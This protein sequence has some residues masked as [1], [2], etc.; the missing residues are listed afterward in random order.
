MA[1]KRYR[2]LIKLCNECAVTCGHC[3]VSCLN[4]KDVEMMRQCIR[5]DLDCATFC[6]VAAEL[7]S[8]DSDHADKFLAL[9]AEVCQ[10]CADECSKHKHQHCKDCADICSRCAEACMELAA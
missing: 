3:A 8:R 7:M 10:A 6:R 9:C 5:L 2:E 1:D 4:E